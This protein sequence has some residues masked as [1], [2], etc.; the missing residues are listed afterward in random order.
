MTLVIAW[1]TT[2]LIEGGH[3]GLQAYKP[4]CSYFYV[5]LR[6]F[7]VFQNPKKRDFLRIFAVFHTFSRTMLVTYHH[8]WSD[9]LMLH[10]VWPLSGYSSL[11]NW[12]EAEHQSVTVRAPPQSDWPSATLQETAMPTAMHT[13]T[14]ACCNWISYQKMPQTRHQWKC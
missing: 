4:I 14:C 9:L 12:P 11:Q 3:R 6:F 5:F 13:H 1:R 7:Y 8:G 2:K 10:C